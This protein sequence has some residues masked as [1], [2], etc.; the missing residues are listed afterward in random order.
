MYL[1]YLQEPSAGPQL[2]SHK[3]QSSKI[4]MSAYITLLKIRNNKN[5]RNR[6]S[7]SRTFL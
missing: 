5:K 2:A 3:S 6:Q 4:R 1:F 7:K